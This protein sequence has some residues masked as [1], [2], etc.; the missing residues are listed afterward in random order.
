MADG[1]C[2]CAD[3][4]WDGIP[5][6]GGS[7]AEDPTIR[8]PH[9]TLV[10]CSDP[11]RFLGHLRDRHGAALGPEPGPLLL[12]DHPHCVIVVPVDPGLHLQPLR[13]QN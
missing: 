3:H 12:V 2:R 5:L 4:R 1:L 8:Q 13:L 7:L 10:G 6:A 11:N 9:W